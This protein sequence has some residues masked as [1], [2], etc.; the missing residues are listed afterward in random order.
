MI[1]DIVTNDDILS[2]LN[3]LTN[4]IRK[5]RSQFIIYLAISSVIQVV[6]FYLILYFTK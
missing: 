6:S 3:E 4:S 2:N 1:K 5:Y